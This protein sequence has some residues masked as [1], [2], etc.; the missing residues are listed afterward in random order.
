LFMAGA[1]ALSLVSPGGTAL[2]A[3]G[4]VNEGVVFPEGV[5]PSG[6]GI[7]G[8]A[9]DE[10]L[11]EAAVPDEVMQKRRNGET[12]GEAGFEG[13][14]PKEPE[15][16]DRASKGRALYRSGLRTAD[17]AEGASSGVTFEKTGDYTY[18]IYANGQPLLIEVSSSNQYS[19]LYIDDNGNGVGDQGEEIIE[20]R[21]DSEVGIYYSDGLGYFL[22]NSSIYGGGKDGVYTYDTNVTLT[23]PSDLKNRAVMA[24]Y[25]GNANGT[26][27]G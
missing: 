27:T 15:S 10:G 25:G 3:L 26:L 1:A 12:S 21:G 24:V 11:R 23:G 16:G 7:A 17:S 4:G 13:E 2:A 8:I 18:N 20:F 14:V 6:A 22:T 19:E 5:T 9:T